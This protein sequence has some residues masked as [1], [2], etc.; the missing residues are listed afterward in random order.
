MK[1]V[2]NICIFGLLA[3]LAG[4]QSTPTVTNNAA[5]GLDPSLLS[6]IQF[7]G[8]SVSGLVTPAMLERYFNARVLIGSKDA[9]AYD[10]LALDVGQEQKRFHVET[11]AQYLAARRQGAAPATTFD[12][13]MDSFFVQAAA[14]GVFLQRAQPAKT[15]LL[16]QTSLLNLT[17][18]DLHLGSPEGHVSVADKRRLMDCQ[19][20]RSIRHVKHLKPN[21]WQFATAD[22]DYILELIA[23]GDVNHDGYQDWLLVVTEYYRGGSGR[24][25]SPY[26]CDGKPDKTGA[27]AARAVP[28]EN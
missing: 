5:T 8:F 11:V 23:V 26:W 20:D 19:R 3:A 4:C 24:S 25:Y 1:W 9:D 21:E 7:A 10:F 2:I 17:A 15:N 13:S 14:A 27:W 22:Q 12:M 28:W 6:P 16:G 18:A